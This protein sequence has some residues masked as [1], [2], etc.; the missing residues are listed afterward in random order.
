[1]LQRENP[2]AHACGF[3]SRFVAVLENTD[4]LI[5][6]NDFVFV[7]IGLRWVLSPN[8]VKGQKDEEQSTEALA[9]LNSSR[10]K[11]NSAS[12][13]ARQLQLR[14]RDSILSSRHAIASAPMPNR[15]A[16]AEM[17]VLL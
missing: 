5:L 10:N 8:H 9:S 16:T 11:S 2:G 4:A 17:I 14:F 15:S 6:K 7:R 12:T 3:V 13:P 1:V